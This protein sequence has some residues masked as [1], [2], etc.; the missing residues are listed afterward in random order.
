MEIY[1]FLNGKL[2]I[3]IIFGKSLFI[4]FLFTLLTKIF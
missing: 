3:K 1:T 2:N 4:A